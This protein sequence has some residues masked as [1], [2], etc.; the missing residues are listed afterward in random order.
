VGLKASVVVC[1]SASNM[2]QVADQ[3]PGKRYVFADND[4]S[5]TGAKA[6]EATGLPWTMCDSVGWDA[7][8]LHK[9]DSLF[10]VVKKIMDLRR[11]VLTGV[12]STC[13]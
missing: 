10:A 3:I 6:A 2:V 7:N 11:N 5:E 8:D 9:K 1:F 13:V 4:A 12:E